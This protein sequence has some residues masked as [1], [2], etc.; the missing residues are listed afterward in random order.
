MTTLSILNASEYFSAGL[1]TGNIFGSENFVRLVADRIDKVIGV[2]DGTVGFIAGVCHNRVF[3]P[4]SAP[5]M[6]LDTRIATPGNEDR[7]VFEEFGAE[8]RS[9]PDFKDKSFRMVTPPLVY[10]RAEHSFIQG[11]RNDSDNVTDSASFCRNLAKPLDLSQWARDTRRNYRHSLRQPLQLRVTQRGMEC[12]DLIAAH[13]A[14]HGYPMAMSRDEV[15]ATACAVPV[16]FFVV[17]RSDEMLAAAYCYRIRRDAVQIINT[18]D[19]Q[20]GRRLYATTFMLHEIIAYYRKQ[21]IEQEGL[22]NAWLDYGPANNAD[23]SF[24]QSLAR[25]KTAHGFLPSSKLIL[26]S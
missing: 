19:T 24:S 23:G 12:Y 13:H 17:T 4:W 10:G 14:A 8:V 26:T 3:S 1:S 18:G 11:F 5:F 22:A 25:F 2:T 20:H 16:D 21:L 6:S 9:L 7:T 15:L